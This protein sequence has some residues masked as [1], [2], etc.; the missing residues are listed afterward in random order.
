MDTFGCC[1]VSIADKQNNIDFHRHRVTTGNF[2]VA[3]TMCLPMELGKNHK[4][5]FQYENVNIKRNRI[6]T[7]E[8]GEY[9]RLFFNSTAIT[10]G[11]TKSTGKWYFI[12]FD[13]GYIGNNYDTHLDIRKRK[14]DNMEDLASN[15]AVIDNNPSYVKQMMPEFNKLLESSYILG[16]DI[17]KQINEWHPPIRFAKN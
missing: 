10:H 6:Q 9:D 16:I 12:T 11:V 15:I 3:F 13:Y 14:I 17:D 7:I 8:C 1:K 2:S 4:F 5:I